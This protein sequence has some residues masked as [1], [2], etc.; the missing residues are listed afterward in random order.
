VLLTTRQ[1]DHAAEV[2]LP[3]AFHY[4]GSCHADSAL[5]DRSLESLVA[6]GLAVVTGSVAR[7]P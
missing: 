5:V 1:P 6:D 2:F 3:K 4:L 7:L